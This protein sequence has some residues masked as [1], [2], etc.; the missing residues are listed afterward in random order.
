MDF[1][2]DFYNESEIEL[3]SAVI[4]EIQ[5]S[6]CGYPDKIF[7]RQQKGKAIEVTRVVKADNKKQFL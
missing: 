6:A 1:H 3:D 2:R 4:Y 7:I 5:M